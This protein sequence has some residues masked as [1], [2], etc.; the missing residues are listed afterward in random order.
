MK[1]LLAMTI[2]VVLGMS[3][4]SAWAKSF[5]DTVINE[6]EKA[7]GANQKVM[8]IFHTD[9][10]PKVVLAKIK[11]AMQVRDPNAIFY[12]YW[13]TGIVSEKTQGNC[14]IIVGNWWT[15]STGDGAS[16]WEPRVYNQ[17]KDSINL[18]SFGYFTSDY[19]KAVNYERSFSV[20]GKT[21]VNT[22]E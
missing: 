16:D 6:M 20:N 18:I 13:V 12:P 21:I 4:T 3:G 1:K 15:G 14:G 22:C 17:V 8:V 19:T 10:S 9:K 11:S 2:A 5:E 7:Y